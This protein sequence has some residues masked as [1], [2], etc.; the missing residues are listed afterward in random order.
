MR[1][2]AKLYELTPQWKAYD[3]EITERIKEIETEFLNSTDPITAKKVEAYHESIR[4]L[5]INLREKH[6]KLSAEERV[7]KIQQKILER[8]EK[9]LK[10]QE[11]QI[12][13]IEQGNDQF[14][15]P[16]PSNQEEEL[17]TVSNINK[18]RTDSSPQR[19]D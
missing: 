8:V 3:K 13:S 15:I 18:N 9:E 4:V 11:Q 6:A 10:S 7:K 19:N 12:Q 14:S 17:V 1:K 2:K 5:S 16:A